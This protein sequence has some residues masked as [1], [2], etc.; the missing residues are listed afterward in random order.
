MYLSNE[1]ARKKRSFPRERSG[2][3]VARGSGSIATA[4]SG[5]AG[6]PAGQRSD[7]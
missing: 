6:R 1:C 2:A 4:G 5:T 7:M 3:A